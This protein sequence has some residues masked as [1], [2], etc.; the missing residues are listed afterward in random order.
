MRGTKLQSWAPP[1]TGKTHFTLSVNFMKTESVANF[2]FWWSLRDWP[3]KEPLQL[4][5]KQMTANI[6][7][8]GKKINSVIFILI[9]QT[10]IQFSQL[11]C[12]NLVEMKCTKLSRWG[13]PGVRS[14][15]PNK[16][17]LFMIQNPNM[18]RVNII[19]Q[20]RQQTDTSALLVTMYY[21][22]LLVLCWHFQ[23]H[24]IKSTASK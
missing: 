22:Y 5:R 15:K 18:L 14:L 20:Y 21:I 17:E 2:I 1:T 4:Q 16:G 19:S 23:L 12:P 6:F 3:W 9:A 24:T 8:H 7:S 13:E 10:G 11:C